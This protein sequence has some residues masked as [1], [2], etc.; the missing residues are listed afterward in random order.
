MA[1]II[2]NVCE[3]IKSIDILP[4]VYIGEKDR[5]EVSDILSF[6]YA[7]KAVSSP[8]KPSKRHQKN[9]LY[10]IYSWDQDNDYKQ[11]EALANTIYEKTLAKKNSYNEIMGTSEIYPQLRFAL[12]GIVANLISIAREKTR[13]RDHIVEIDNLLKRLLLMNNKLFKKL[14]LLL[15]EYFF[16]HVYNED[17]TYKYMLKKIKKRL[18]YC[19]GIKQSD[20]YRKISEPRDDISYTLYFAEKSGE[21]IRRKDG[22]SYR[23]Y[24]PECKL[25]E[26]TPL[27]DPNK[28]TDVTGR[29]YDYKAVLEKLKALLKENEGILQSKFY[30]KCDEPKETVSSILYFVEKDKYIVRKKEGRSYRLYLTE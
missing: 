8:G 1:N 29:E 11:Y 19:L 27:I 4:K 22:R 13:L 17:S 16:W 23:L 10:Q 26:I 3:V 30:A 24:L 14:F 12:E 5:Q 7:D 18:E 21:I 25:K 20:F 2:E 15:H 28:K 6:V 9:I